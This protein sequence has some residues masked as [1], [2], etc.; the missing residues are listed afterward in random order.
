MIKLNLGNLKHYNNIEFNKK[1]MHLLIQK[2]NSLIYQN[3]KIIK[4]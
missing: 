4:K 3:Q 1:I 2:L